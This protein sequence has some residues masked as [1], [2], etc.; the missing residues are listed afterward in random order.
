[1]HVLATRSRYH[2]NPA[3]RNN[4]MQN[5]KVPI[6]SI[7]TAIQSLLQND[8]I[9]LCRPPWKETTF[10]DIWTVKTSSNVVSL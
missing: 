10:T 2:F 6:L 8:R 1:M 4:T 9:I 7:K 5:L 3:M